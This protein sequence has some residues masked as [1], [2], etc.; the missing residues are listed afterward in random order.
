MCV[1]VC[2][3]VFLCVKYSCLSNARDCERF[4]II[5]SL[6]FHWFIEEWKGGKKTQRR[7]PTYH[8]LSDWVTFEVKT[9]LHVLIYILDGTTT[10]YCE[11]RIGYRMV[12]FMKIS[13]A[14]SFYFSSYWLK[15]CHYKWFINFSLVDW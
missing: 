3:F 5:C 13:L 15:L 6:F 1:C 8:I 2:V 7:P 12:K 4:E 9:I 14:T 10:T 11:R